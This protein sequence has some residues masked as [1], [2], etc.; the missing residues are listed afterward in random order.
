MVEV[1][2][3]RRVTPHGVQMVP[4]VTHT[5]LDCVVHDADVLRGIVAQ[6]LP[7]LSFHEAFDPNELLFA[8]L[9]EVLGTVV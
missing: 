7:L 8:F 1:V 2:T 6:T 3:A 4:R 5:L 9:V